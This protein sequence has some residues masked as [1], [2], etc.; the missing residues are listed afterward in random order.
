[1]TA[2]D[3]AGP[4]LLPAAAMAGRNDP[5]DRILATA[6]A[7]GLLRS[8]GSGFYLTNRYDGDIPGWGGLAQ[9][10]ELFVGDLND[11]GRDDVV[12]FNGQDWSMAYVGLFEVA[13]RG[14]AVQSEAREV[15]LAVHGVLVAAE[16]YEA[17]S[18]NLRSA[19]RGGSGASATD[20]CR[21]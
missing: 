11:D 7:F 13:R 14:G 20:S 16:R 18:H 4:T 15:A 5:A 8:T 3:A 21:R 9:H 1:M 6:F 2:N 19:G 10:D 17:D 12:I